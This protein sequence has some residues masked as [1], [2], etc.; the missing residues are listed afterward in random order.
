MKPLHILNAL[1]FPPSCASCGEI[2]PY[3]TEEPFCTACRGKWEAEK[4][5]CCPGCHKPLSECRCPI[6]GSEALPCI[7]LV[8]Y[9]PDAKTGESPAKEM[10]LSVKEGR[11]RRTEDFLA[12]QLAGQLS[13][14]FPNRTDTVMTYVPR[15]RVKV[16]VTGTDQ[17][18]VIAE[19]TAELLGI[20]ICPVLVRGAGKAA[21]QKEL[22][23]SERE[24]NASGAYMLS[25]NAAFR[26]MCCGKHMI[27]VDDIITSGATV[28]ACASLLI[29]AGA[30]SVT[31]AS[32]ARTLR[33]KHVPPQDTKDV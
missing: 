15:K 32:V 22:N 3:Y 10:L 17:A 24:K 13:P 7:S 25:S 6:P 11:Q 30:A 26:D 23:A 19:K 5:R 16:R 1:L 21:D 4:R 18:R 33:Q 12:G 2:L 20:P 31:A 8:F 27:L 28:H 14:R 9:D 29:E